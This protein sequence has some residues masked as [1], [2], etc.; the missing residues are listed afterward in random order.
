[1]YVVFFHNTSTEKD[2]QNTWNAIQTIIYMSH[3]SHVSVFA[4]NLLNILTE[5]WTNK[6]KYI[7]HDSHRSA[8]IYTVWIISAACFERN[9]KETENIFF[10]CFL[11]VYS[12]WQHS[13]EYCKRSFILTFLFTVYVLC[14][15]C[16][17]FN[18]D[19]FTPFIVDNF[20]LRIHS[21]FLACDIFH[22][23]AFKFGWFLIFRLQR[24]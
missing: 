5:H 22:I 3:I 12:N 4:A 13:V 1:M 18:V 10:L 24:I 8:I 16:C 23:S 9:K 2:Q 19:F 14:V 21:F 17:D 11:F 20:L 6:L 7:L 15:F